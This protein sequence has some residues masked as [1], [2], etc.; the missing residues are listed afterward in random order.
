MMEEDI[1]FRFQYSN[2]HLPIVSWKFLSVIVAWAG[3][4]ILKL[5]REIQA[6]KITAIF[7]T[8]KY[9]SKYFGEWK[10]QYVMNILSYYI[11]L[12]L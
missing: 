7:H 1:H 11:Q 3:C 10:R 12:I 5:E 8:I 6:A 9:L 2:M 4:E